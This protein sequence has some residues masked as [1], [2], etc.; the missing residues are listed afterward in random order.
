VTSLWTRHPAATSWCLVVA[1]HSSVVSACRGRFSIFD[2]AEWSERPPHAERCDFCQGV[3]ID[4]RL[5]GLA[6]LEAMA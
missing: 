6:E 5:R 1:V 2:H 4:K 3:A